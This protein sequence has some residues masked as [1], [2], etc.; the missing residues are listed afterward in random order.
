MN[1]SLIS[2]IA[3][4]ALVGSIGLVY[5]QSQGSDTYSQPAAT[6][7]DQSTQAATTDS[8]TT[9]SS[10]STM[11]PDT[12]TGSSSSTMSDDSSLAAQADRN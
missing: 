7:T 8:T 9:P 4:A 5:A 3:A 10:S 1:K 6:P 12:S 2:S 11:S